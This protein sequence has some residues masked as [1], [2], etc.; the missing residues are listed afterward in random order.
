M[1]THD[2]PIRA[3]IP[4]PRLAAW[5]IEP[6]LHSDRR[7]M[8][9]HC[10][11]ASRSL[12]AIEVIHLFTLIE[13]YWAPCWERGEEDGVK[14]KGEGRKLRGRTVGRMLLKEFRAS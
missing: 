14:N 5:V 1:R 2:K 11:Q 10:A 13:R 6:A 12:L 3:T 8:R 9:V 4:Q 7:Q